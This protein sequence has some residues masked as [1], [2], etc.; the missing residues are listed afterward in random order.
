V[1][2]PGF[3]SVSSV[4]PITLNQR[5]FSDVRLKPQPLVPPGSTFKAPFAGFRVSIGAALAAPINNKK[6]KI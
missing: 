5:V 4:E 3:D 2:S 6:L 1:P